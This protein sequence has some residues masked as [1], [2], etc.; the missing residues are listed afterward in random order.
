MK[1]GK[2]LGLI[3]VVGLLYLLWQIRQLMLLLYAAITFATIINKLV[4]QVQRLSIPRG[5]A[6]MIT[7]IMVFGLLGAASWF[8]VPTLITQ[9]PQ[10]A[11][12]SE[13]G[14]DR[15]Q[16]WYRELAGIV[17]GDALAQT[18]LSD[19]LPQLAQ[20]SPSWIGRL[21]ALFAGSVDFLINLLLVLVTTVML[22]ANPAAYRRLLLLA[23]PAFYR[24]R[25][26]EILLECEQA[27]TGWAVG[28]LFNV[29]VITVFSAIG[30]AVIGVPLPYANA[31]IAG[32]LTVIPNIGPVL[33][34]IPP[35][36][37]AI[38]VAP[39]MAPAVIGLYFVIQQLESTVLTPI[40]MKQQVS[41]LPA[42]ALISQVVCAIFFGPLGLFLALP[43]VVVAQVWLRE[44]LVKDI[45]NNWTEPGLRLGSAQTKIIVDESPSGRVPSVVC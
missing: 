40:V 26:D 16:S 27:L 35:T 13:L 37:M 21:V 43:I 36:L 23:F 15:I 33:S 28:I 34:L 11:S 3:G 22:L 14:I 41:L 7:L 29:A 30:L 4:R 39:W 42:V 8:A 24:D 6:V 9:I 2:L 5:W 10:Y 12:L 18:K 38:G 45:L 17:P 20:M 44:L 19:L 1:F 31:V 25:A 32:L